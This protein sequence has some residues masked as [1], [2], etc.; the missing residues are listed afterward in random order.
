VCDSEL[1]AFRLSEQTGQ[2]FSVG[3]IVFTKFF[4]IELP[5]VDRAA[6]VSLPGSRN[7]RTLN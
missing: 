1:S 7:A 3:K 2:E 5:V 4:T 6:V